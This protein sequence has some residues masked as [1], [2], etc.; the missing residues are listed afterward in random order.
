MRRLGLIRALACWLALSACGAAQQYVFRAY[1]QSEGLNNLAVNALVLD[2]KGFLWVGTENGLYR[3]LGTGFERFGPEHGI[4][5]L[6]IHAL[7]VDANGT[8]WVGTNQNLYRSEGQ[9][10]VPVSSNAIHVT[11]WNSM[12]VED[13]RDLLIVDGQR[14]FRLVHDD[15]GRLLSYSPV[16][17]EAQVK[18][19]P[20]LAQLVGV[21]VVNDP[22]AGIQ[23]FAG[24]G[25]GLYSWTDREPGSQ[26]QAK[27]AK[28]TE[29][30]KAEGLDEDTW[31]SV[32]LD[33]SGTLW[34]GGL[35][36]V[37]VLP[38]GAARFLDRSIPGSNPGNTYHHAPFV[39]D[40]D[41]RVLVPSEE[42]IARW[43]GSRWQIIGAANGLQVDTHIANLAFDQ[44][45][46]LWLAT[47][48]NGLISWT[49]YGDWEGWN[50]A[51]GLPSSV[52]WAVAPSRDGRVYL[53]TD[54]GPAWVDPASGSSGALFAT[55]RWAF[56]QVDTLGF[57]LDGS[58]W[59]G[60]FSATILRINPTTR[61]AEQ[62]AKLTLFLTH[63]LA[64]ANG[65]VYFTTNQGIYERDL[66]DSMAIPRKVTAVDPLLTG[67]SQVDAACKTPDGTLWF[68]ANKRLLR[69]KGGQWDQPPIDNLPTLP[70]LMFDL[71]CASDGSVWMTGQQTGAWRLTPVRDRLK[72]WQLQLP[73]EFQTVV[74]VAIVVDSRG[75]VWLGTDYGLLAWD[76]SSWRHL[77][78]ESGLLW[79]DVNQG[80][81]QVGAD[82]SLWIGTSGG[83]SHLL[84]PEH[85]FDA[86]P[87]TIEVTG[88][89]RGDSQYSPALE[90]TLPWS[91]QPL[92]LQ[93][94]A[95]VM[96]NASEMVFRYRM[97]G[98]Q[99]DWI[100]STDGRAVYS[101][102]PPGKFTFM[103]V[104]HNAGL[105]ATSNTV[106]VSINVLP[107]WWR[108]NWFFGL[109]G[110]AGLVLLWIGDKLRSRHLSARSRELEMLVHERTQE[111]EASEE[112]LRIL[113]MQ[114]GLTGMLNHLAIMQALTA[115]MERA[116]REKTTLVV[117]MIDLDHFKHVND[118]YGH[119][120]GDEALR[121]FSAVVTAATRPYDHAGR[122]GGEEFLI[123]LVNVPLAA[124]QHRLTQLHNSIS[125][126]EVSWGKSTFKLTCSMGA[127]TYDPHKGVEEAEA[128]LA[129]A[130]AAL[131]AAKGA[132][133][134][135]IVIRDANALEVG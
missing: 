50:V 133:R 108:S 33:R 39:Q 96:R 23:V 127:V 16:F 41:G 65:H 37:E 61:A 1:R 113:A 120:A 38:R 116:R 129:G 87:L 82:G 76:G 130:D 54:N 29:W 107:P 83:L 58:L 11:G 9:G 102:L 13:A 53:G 52:I 10:F 98:L 112:K 103:A 68:L 90:T 104:A 67:S 91:R 81:M 99:A 51:Q 48:G 40:R 111:L 95:S 32:M 88:M 6:F 66:S 94:S 134:N 70:G 42:G 62:A 44:T 35:K 72:A 64:D 109:C 131:Y 73:R 126:I 31:E 117:G 106:T 63:S 4:A 118:A 45:G 5:E 123:V 28:V 75:W 30:G 22:Q 124:A 132:G 92:Q 69:L 59:A 135:C 79:N 125:N 122:Y 97:E 60:T 78:Q 55:K 3:F 20:E 46:D 57:N 85:V 7:A 2:H 89:K 74:P 93:I 86:N 8:I 15:Q 84:H 12:A 56:G 77:T 47:R 128:L 19:K 43:D 18:A 25:K 36:R 34:A 17:P 27:I 21:S 114:D 26:T 115:E 100:E 101:N 105:N 14:L 71:S 80:T 110:I 121:S 24:S 119:L 49:G